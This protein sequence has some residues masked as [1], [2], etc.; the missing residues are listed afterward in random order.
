MCINK[1][2]HKVAKCILIMLLL[3]QRE[4]IFK[5]CYLCTVFVFRSDVQVGRVQL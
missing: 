5:D 2:V 4:T 1:T 3:N